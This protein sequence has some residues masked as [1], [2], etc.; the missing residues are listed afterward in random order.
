MDVLYD[1]YHNYSLPNT[2]DSDDILKVTDFKIKVTGQHF[3]KM[4][5]PAKA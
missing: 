1:T 4:H 3:P 5:F 2:R